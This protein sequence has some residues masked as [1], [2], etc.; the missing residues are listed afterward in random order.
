LTTALIFI[1]LPSSLK[2]FHFQSSQKI[3]RM[4]VAV[5]ENHVR[6]WSVTLDFNF[7]KVYYA[8][9]LLRRNNKWRNIKYTG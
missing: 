6:G 2:Q 3:V 9:R 4:P 5:Q 7:M 8:I 1:L